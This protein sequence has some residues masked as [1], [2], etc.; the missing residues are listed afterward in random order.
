MSSMY[1]SLV[2]RNAYETERLLDLRDRQRLI[3]MSL[4]WSNWP[5]SLSYDTPFADQSV[6]PMMEGFIRERAE[7]LIEGAEMSTALSCLT[8]AWQAASLQH[9]FRW[10]VDEAPSEAAISGFNIVANHIAAMLQDADQGME[11]EFGSG[12]IFSG[13]RFS[14][15]ESQ[16]VEIGSLLYWAERFTGDGFIDQLIKT[17][18]VEAF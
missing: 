7:T 10:K 13:E 2:P 5:D 9:G 8:T 15:I 12:G 4:R 11:S 16:I 14:D 1:K 6:S 3:L 18:F 17:C